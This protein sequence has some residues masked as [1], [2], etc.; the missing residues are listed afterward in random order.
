MKH[1]TPK[2]KGFYIYGRNVVQE[3]LHDAPERLREIFVVHDTARNV[4][5]IVQLARHNKIRVT[6]IDKTKALKLFGHVQ[7][8]GIGAYYAGYQYASWH[9]IQERVNKSDR[10][11]VVIIDGIEDVQNFGAIIR[12]A[13][14]VGV[15]A[16]CVPSHKQAPINSVVF[17][18]SAGSV[19]KVPII[20]FAG[21]NQMI[22]DVQKD[23]FWV[24]GIDMDDGNN[25]H[26][27]GTIWDQ[28]FDGRSAIVV[29]AEGRGIS[30]KVREHC[31]FVTP[32]PM[33]NGVESL[34]VSVA[35]AVVLYEWKRQG[36]VKNR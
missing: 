6:K 26:P 9:D 17:T 21:T 22:A 35:T 25:P 13:A 36:M 8:Q 3:T 1:R 15:T 16:I 31:D 28:S 18:T 24:Y 11:L 33:E 5:N 19:H 2:A 30:Q 34:N 10:A 12:S 4:E 7:T 23:D 27:A 14:A 32:I 29:G 20:Q